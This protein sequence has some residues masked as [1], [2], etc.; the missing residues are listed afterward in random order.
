MGGLSLTT[1]PNLYESDVQMGVIFFEI[2]LYGD[3][4]LYER[5][6]Y[7]YIYN[8]IYIIYNIYIY[9]LYGDNILFSRQCTLYERNRITLKTP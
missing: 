1:D 4:I 2:L 6:M 5:N 3:N 9:I 8:I 7:I